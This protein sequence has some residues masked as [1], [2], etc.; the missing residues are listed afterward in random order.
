MSL[1]EIRKTTFTLPELKK[2]EILAFLNCCKKSALYDLYYLDVTEMEEI[3]LPI[4]DKAFYL[5]TRF[6]RVWGHYMDKGGE[7]PWHK[8][9]NV[10]MLFYLQIPDGD[11][12]SCVH[13]EGTITPKEN[14]LYI[15]PAKLSHKITPNRTNETRWA[16]ASECKPESVLFR[17]QVKSR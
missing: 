14:D 9:N 8:H 1:A 11:C 16:I 10:T 13:P 7:R 12:G 4:L 6:E 2:E 17:E 15:F 3:F 5:K